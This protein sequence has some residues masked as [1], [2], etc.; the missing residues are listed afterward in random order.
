MASS[1][2]NADGNA[3]EFRLHYRRNGRRCVISYDTLDAALDHAFRRLEKDGEVELWISDAGRRVLLDSAAIWARFALR[4][5][6]ASGGT[7]H[8]AK[9]DGAES[10]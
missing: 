2:T 7:G 9:A 3:D 10:S 4:R 1:L 6:G 5:D 8:G